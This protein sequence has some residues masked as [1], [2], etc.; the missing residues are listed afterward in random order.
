MQAFD[1]SEITGKQ[2]GR[3]FQSL[4]DKLSAEFILRVIPDF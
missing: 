3:G 1:F 4:L 2:E